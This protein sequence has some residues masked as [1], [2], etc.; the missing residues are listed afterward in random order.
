MKHGLKNVFGF[1]AGTLLALGAG[2][3][4]AQTTANGPYYATPSWDQK[5]QCDTQ[6]TCPRFVLLSNW[7]DAAFPSGGAAVLDRETGLVWQRS[8][9]TSPA[10]FSRASINC[11]QSTTGGRFG[12]RMPQTEE[13]FSLLDPG[14]AGSLGVVALPA[15]HPFMN[16]ASG[17]Y[18][19]KD[20]DLPPFNADANTFEVRLDLGEINETDAG[21]E[22]RLVW[23]VR[24]PG[25]SPTP[26]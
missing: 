13:L 15:G 9:T 20:R 17:P 24:G 12:W 19:V 5:L 8:P 14:R 22:T 25:G 4:G 21:T 11:Q 3:A 18:W 10:S 7:A 2:S 16:V 6:A 26:W 1:A 23:C